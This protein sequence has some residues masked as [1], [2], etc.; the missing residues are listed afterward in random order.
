MENYWLFY[1]LNVL[2]RLAL[3]VLFLWPGILLWKEPLRVR[4]MLERIAQR[5][6]WVSDELP[7]HA[8]V[9]GGGVGRVLVVVGGVLL[10]WTIQYAW[11]QARP[12][13]AKSYIEG[14]EPYKMPPNIPG[15]NP[16]SSSTDPGISGYG[17]PPSYGY[18]QPGYGTSPT[19]GYGQPGYT[20]TPYGGYGTP[21]YAPPQPPPPR[22]VPGAA[23][24]YAPR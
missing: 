4:R 5:F 13:P 8:P 1:A 14:V 9:V 22:G 18:G 17:A 10:V 11:V 6:E 19:Y 23:G 3:A 21:G 15:A 20:P 24:G 16:Q 12:R 7:A 2:W